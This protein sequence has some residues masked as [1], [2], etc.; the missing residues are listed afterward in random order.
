MI[1]DDSP[2][3]AVLAQ[4]SVHAVDLATGASLGREPD[5]PWMLA[6][7][8]KL[9]WAI[10]AHR[11]A[12][13]GVLDL[14]SRLRVDPSSGT[15]GPTGLSTLRDPV[16]LSARDALVLALSLSDNACADALFD[17]LGPDLIRQELAAVAEGTFDRPIRSLYDTLAET[18]QARSGEAMVEA[19]A[20]LTAPG[21]AA[22]PVLDPARGNA[23]TAR[24][25]TALI[26]ALW[27][28]DVASPAACAAVRDALAR[29]ALTGRLAAAFG[30]DA[31]TAGKTGTLLTL[32]HEVAHVELTDG[33]AYAVAVLSRAARLG[34]GRAHDIAVGELGLAAVRRLRSG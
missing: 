34:D 3:P 8:V 27:R 33:S 16:E 21:T 12:D 10:A 18:T 25:L 22:L 4:A 6:S 13:R 5:R 2:L 7:V 28:D 1:H 19:I 11:A 23:A 14:G 26:A 20:R 9:A 32:R 30:D 31:R 24:G 15:P 29:P 17:F